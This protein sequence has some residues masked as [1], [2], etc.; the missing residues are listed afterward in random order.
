MSTRTPPG[1]ELDEEQDVEGL[2]V[3]GATSVPDSAWVTQQ[4]RN[5]S[6]FGGLEDE[7]I[8]LRDRDAKFSGPFDEVLRTEGLKVV[9][10]PSVRRGRT[11]SRSSGSAPF[12]ESAST[13]C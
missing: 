10:T 3:A 1:G 5:L 12:D 7:R 6:I 9:K 13:T 2:R 8:L 11:R 4:A